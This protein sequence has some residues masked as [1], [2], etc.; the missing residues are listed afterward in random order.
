LRHPAARALE[1]VQ[2]L[3]LRPDPHPLDETRDQS[4]PLGL[5]Q[6]ALEPELHEASMTH[7]PRD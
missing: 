1:R 7:P 5:R 4:L 2:E 3:L 6:V